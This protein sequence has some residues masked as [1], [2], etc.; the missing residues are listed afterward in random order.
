MIAA[1][2]ANQGLLNGVDDSEI[3]EGTRGFVL[4]TTFVLKGCE[5]LLAFMKS[6]KYQSQLH[7]SG[8]RDLFATSSKP[9][10]VNFNLWV[11]PKRAYYGVK[12]SNLPYDIHDGV[13]KRICLI[14]PNR[15]GKT[16]EES[17][18]FFKTYA[19]SLNKIHD[20][21]VIT[22]KDLQPRLVSFE[23]KRSLVKSY[24]MFIA[25]T[26]LRDFLIPKLGKVFKR[27]QKFP[28][29]IALHRATEL[30]RVLSGTHF[31]LHNEGNNYS[32]L[33]GHSGMKPKELRDNIVESLSQLAKIVPNGWRNI[34]SAGITGQGTA[35]IPI[36]DSSHEAQFN[37]LSQ[38]YQ[39]VIVKSEPVQNNQPNQP[40]EV[41][42]N[43][44]I[45]DALH[46]KQGKKFLSTFSKISE[47]KEKVLKLSVAHKNKAQMGVK[48]PVKSKSAK[49]AGKQKENIN[50]HVESVESDLKNQA[51]VEEN[52]LPKVSSN[53][54]EAPRSGTPDDK[55]SLGNSKKLRSTSD[56]AILKTE[57]RKLKRTADKLSNDV[58]FTG[59]E[60]HLLADSPKKKKPK[61]QA[62]S[63][64]IT[65]YEK[66]MFEDK[67]TSDNAKPKERQNFSPKLSGYE[68]HMFD[69]IAEKTK[70][71]KSKSQCEYKLT[72]Y[73]KFS[74][75]EDSQT[76]KKSGK[77]RKSS[78]SANTDVDIPQ[79]F[80]DSENETE[81]DVPPSAKKKRSVS[82]RSSVATKRVQRMSSVAE[83]TPLRRSKRL[84]SSKQ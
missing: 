1:R 66:H 63:P 54:E 71:K 73:D 52:L 10:H 79:H 13:S 40:M 76:R 80:F 3:A 20:F 47:L 35:F 29:N 65:G 57:K 51:S 26:S 11:I 22:W 64:H 8:K 43:N 83:N 32:Y 39:Q 78:E 4:S 67:E 44:G 36:Y 82:S 72:G 16:S 27:C 41:G 59:R 2:S 24:D 31:F 42:K 75:R 25:D 9:I 69:D 17:V 28:I 14:V 38:I 68:K 84:H 70:K 48:T 33:I 61:T 34:R 18:Q 49:R 6:A 81:V 46:F 50:K 5:A 12:I 60:V 19:R 56:A 21:D 55:S 23:E 30:K 15:E 58:E 53:V 45:D 7:R 62:S 77:V 37:T 74:M